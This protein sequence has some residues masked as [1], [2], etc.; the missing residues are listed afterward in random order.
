[1]E[2]RRFAA[3]LGRPIDYAVGRVRR[4]PP[5]SAV[6]CSTATGGTLAELLEAW[7]A[8]G[9]ADPGFADDLELVGSLDTV[10]EDPWASVDDPSTP[11]AA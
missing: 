7:R 10:P 2:L 6:P 9:P 8:S 1:M 11:G 5:V 3:A 4:R